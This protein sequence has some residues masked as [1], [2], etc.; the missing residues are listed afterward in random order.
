MLLTVIMAFAGA[1]T[2]RAEEIVEAG[3]WGTCPWE[4]SDT[5]VLTVYPGEGESQ[6]SS[7]RSPWFSHK[8]EITSVVFK[9]DEDGSKVVAPQD[10]RYLLRRLNLVL[11]VD[12]SGLDVSRVEN[13]SSMFSG[14]SS[15]SSLDASGWNT[16]N[17]ENMSYMF[18]DCSALASLDVSDWNTGNVQYM[19]SMFEGCSSLA[20]LDVSGWNTGN[21]QY[22][23]SMFHGCSALSSL[24]A[25]GW[26]TGNVQYMTSMFEGC[27]ALSS[28]N[29]SGWNTGNVQGM[30]SM[31]HGCSS[32][33]SLEASGWNTGNVQ[34]MSFM[35][36]GCSSLSSLDVS[37]W[38]TGNVQDM[39]G[40]F[41]GCSS[42]SS[43]DV[44]GWNTGNVQ[45][46]SSMF[47][48][49]SSLSSLDA[50]G[51][52]TGKVQYMSVMFFGCSALE[53]ICVGNSWSTA[54]VTSSTNMF[55][56]CGHLV[57]GDGTTY[58]PAHTNGD[59]A[60]VDGEGGPGYLTR[61]LVKNGDIYT[62][63]NAA[64]WNE[65]CDALLNLDTY[66][67]FSGKTV[68]LGAD[69]GTAQNPVTRM[70]GSDKHDFCGTFDG[71]GHT[72]TVNISSDDGHVYTAPFSY[73]SETT[74]TGGSEVSHPAIRNLNVAGTV[75]A[76]KDYA[77]GIVGA[78]WGTLT[79][80]NC[81]SSVTIYA[82]KRYAAGFISNAQGNATIENCTSSVT[83]DTNEKYAT[84]F[85][86]NAQG[87]ATIRNCLSSVAINSRVSGDGTH[88]GFIGVTASDKTYTI[89]GCAFTG[90]LETP[91]GTTHCAGFVG[92]NN[93]T[94]T[95]TNSLYAP[96]SL[97]VGETGSATFA[98]NW[99]MPADAN[100]Y[101]TFT[102]GTA[103]SK[104]RHSVTAGDGVTVAHAGVATEYDVSGIKAYKAT[105][106]S[107]DDDPFMAGL[108]YNNV[109]YAGNGD[110]VNLTLTNTA[111]GAPLGYQY[112]GYTAS[113][114]TLS[115]SD[116]PYTLT[117]PDADV[118]LSVALRSTGEPVS[119]SYIDADGQPASHDAI[120][121]DGTEN[122]LGQSG[123][124]TWYFVGTNISHTGQIQ[125]QGN[126]NIIL[127]D[128]CT[129]TTS[130]ED[131]G[132]SGNKDE[133][134]TIYGQTLG[135]GTLVASGTGSNSCS[136][137]HRGHVV[138]CGGT[139]NASGHFSI[140][141]SGN[142]TICGGTVN[143]SNGVYG[144][145]TE[146]N[147][148]ISGGTVNTS[149]S[150]Y[151]IWANKGNV[152]ISGGKVTATGINGIYTSSNGTVTL[153][154]TNAD[155]FVKASSYHGTVTI[156][157]GYRFLTDD[158]TPQQVSDPV[159]DLSVI[160][161]KKLT[162][163]TSYIPDYR[164]SAD[165][166]TYTIF[167]AGGW[168]AFRNLLTTNN[169]GYFSGKTVKLG[170]NITV[171]QQAGNNDHAFTGTFDGQGNTITLDIGTTQPYTAGYVALFRN[172]ETGAN[173]HSLVVDGHIYTQNLRA[174]GIVAKSSGTV[175]ISNCHVS[176]II[177]SSRNGNGYHGGIV[178][179][180]E[181]N[182]ELNI[183][184]C[185]FD[186][187]LLT[188]NGTISCAGFVGNNAST[189]KITNCLYAPADPDEGETWVGTDASAT[190]ARHGDNNVTNITNSYYTETFGTEQGTK[191][192]ALTTAPANLGAKV[193]GE[194][195]TVL[196]AYGNGILYDGKYYVAPEEVTLYDN[197]TN[198]L[199]GVSGYVADVTLSGRKLW[200]DGA[201]NTLCLPFD[202]TVGSGQMEGATAMTLNASTSGFVASTGV[203]TLNFTSVAS[204][205]TIAAGTPFIV[206]WTGDNIVNP[207][208]SGVTIS[209]TAPA[210]D[211]IS[212]DGNV[213]FQGTYN[214]QEYTTE[215]KS[216]LFLG[217]AN[218]L[219][220]PQ[221]SGENIPTIGAFRAYFHVDLNGGANAVR[222][223]VLNFGSDE[224]TSLREISNEKLV[225]S[226]DDYYSLDGRKISGKPTVKGVYIVNGRKIVIK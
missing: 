37:G 170:A 183:T 6:S 10:C 1:Q 156:P 224:S 208:F 28:L 197:A 226:N 19:T 57:G 93:G 77:S 100:C 21:V 130:N 65:F 188:T 43:L 103:Q 140:L 90:K 121:I 165:G 216:I 136:I 162:P 116:N 220:W 60:H 96:T 24:D 186:G 82:D 200:K 205:N 207:V 221:P 5:G 123:Q 68:Y 18:D 72:L 175:S 181:I 158:E 135:S 203:L 124:E 85:I 196:T 219:Y 151:G 146:G 14:C 69:I 63:Y 61:G 192:Y 154:W 84:G 49:C 32:L 147:V 139:V 15:L 168:D 9:E 199:T 2:A 195:I 107:G 33:S 215:D 155:D 202:V 152:T 70:A 190:F 30:S 66:N 26:N 81:T 52:N 55:Y 189:V 31:F 104:E 179:L 38:N 88:A 106:A 101:Y 11:S 113:A 58:D 46:M 144:I 51:W 185:V 119:V 97:N 41:E 25:S 172:V 213:R 99:T 20:S 143:A 174:A 23:T 115:G 223:F 131:D 64:G 53:A 73:I 109:L 211:V 128:G 120:A 187:K 127:A 83:I 137:A 209:S 153:A 12:V 3:T 54:A 118:T 159:S 161:N 214:K 184:G 71:Q 114:G 157:T 44:S 27:S 134:L 201:W 141:V 133:T 178:A 149:G 126:V 40:M 45:Y 110:Q 148:T 16:G 166:N 171:T 167:T 194:E 225:I 13:M 62:I 212:E 29:A 112:S 78:F 191:A 8:D 92:Y 42:L 67:R 22:M 169:K 198:D 222:S 125:C 145:S 39:S 48:G 176:T 87:N 210:T 94:L 108:I 34:G 17:V 173:I 50:S 177:H 163:D 138:I 76:S 164:V 193:T 47:H 105:G 217:E 102:L 79:I 150:Y 35:F 122:E 98:R 86:S 56:G 117:M 204:G 4:I 80:E 180:N 206:K 36:H 91:S 142:V 59:Y 89:E 95:I 75:N 132:I 129:M 218:T 111:T 182:S 160:N 74:P 7:S